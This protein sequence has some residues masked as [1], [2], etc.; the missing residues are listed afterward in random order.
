MHSLTRERFPPVIARSG[1][2]KQSPV[3]RTTGENSDCFL[4]RLVAGLAMTGAAKC[5]RSVSAYA[6]IREH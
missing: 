3:L 6:V 1:T 2:T 4:P 5:A